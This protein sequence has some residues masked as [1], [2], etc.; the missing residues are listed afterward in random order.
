MLFS[1]DYYCYTF[2]LG[3]IQNKCQNPMKGGV[4]FYWKKCGIS[5]P[6]HRFFFQA[7]TFFFGFSEKFSKFFFNE[8]DCKKFSNFFTVNFIEK[9]SKMLYC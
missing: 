6:R 2:I 7:K 5:P 8:I 3:A 1:Y 4:R 9:N